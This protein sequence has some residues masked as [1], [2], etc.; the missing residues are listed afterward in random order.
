MYPDAKGEHPSLYSAEEYSHYFE[1]LYG[2]T[3]DRELA[4]KSV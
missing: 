2:N 4:N 3:K 1:Y